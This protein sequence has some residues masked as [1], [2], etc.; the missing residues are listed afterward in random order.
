MVLV[1]CP[2]CA[3]HI[4]TSETICP[5]CSTAIADDLSARAVPGPR[6][7]L[8]RLA[9]F[10]FAT[11]VTTVAALAGTAACTSST[12]L[13]GAPCTDADPCTVQDD[14]GSF[15]DGGGAQPLYGA[16]AYD[17]GP[18]DDGGNISHYGLPDISDAGDGGD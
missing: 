10:T 13:Y 17:S 6:G 5:F 4:A 1:P 2:S 7:R 15:N 9:T 8:S 16:A 11:T 14:G 18:N 3:R 12:A